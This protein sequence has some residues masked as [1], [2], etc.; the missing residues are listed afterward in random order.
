MLKDMGAE[1]M[2]EADAQNDQIARITDKAD[3]N[4]N[5]IDENVKEGNAILT[6][7]RKNKC[8]NCSLQ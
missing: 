8:L 3:Q 7:E 4:R 5:R 6:R 2:M 1:I